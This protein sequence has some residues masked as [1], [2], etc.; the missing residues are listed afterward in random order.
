MA[1]RNEQERVSGTNGGTSGTFATESA[2]SAV[3]AG[4]VGQ[5]GGTSGG[6]S[7]DHDGGEVGRGAPGGGEGVAQGTGGSGGEAVAAGA[8]RATPGSG[9]PGDTGDL[10]GGQGDDFAARLGGD[11]DGGINPMT[12][13][14]AASGDMSAGRSEGSAADPNPAALGA[15]DVGG[16]G[17]VR[18]PATHG[19]PP[20]GVSPV[21]SSRD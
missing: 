1:D 14:A 20:G 2:G 10:G 4:A 15:G 7:A 16:M 6:G 18:S 13:Q 19:N 9:T 12:P 11:T 3:G 21:G 5:D 17:G 8:G